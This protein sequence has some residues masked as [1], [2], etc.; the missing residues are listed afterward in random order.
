MSHIYSA[1]QSFMH[2]AII[3]LTN[4][5]IYIVNFYPS[6]NIKL[7]KNALEWA[8]QY[9]E[10]SESDKNIIIQARKSVLNFEGSPWT[11]KNCP[12]FDVPMGSYDGA[13]VCDIVGLFLLSELEQLK[14][15][16]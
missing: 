8:E 9:V 1:T 5:F 14:L 4:I 2:K 15:N 6:I 10:I 13:D 7:L 3:R 12:D 16:G 11:K